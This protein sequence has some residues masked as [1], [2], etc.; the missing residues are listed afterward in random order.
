MK[1][2]VASLFLLA[3]YASAGIELGINLSDGSY[4]DVKS[5]ISPVISTSGGKENDLE[6]G[7]TVDLASDGLPKSIWGQKTASAE[8]WGVKTRVELTQGKYPY[9]GGTGAYVTVEA[10]DDDKETFLWSSGVISKGEGIRSLKVGAKKVFET[11]AGKIMIQPRRNFDEDSTEVVLGFEKD[12]TDAYL[13]ISGDAKDLLVK[14]KLDD[15]NSASLKIGCEGFISASITRESDLGS[16]KLTL[17]PDELDVE[18]SKDGWVAGV[19]CDKNLAVA[20]PKVRF[21][22][23]VSFQM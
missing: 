6:Y 23:G 12:D 20:E 22:K 17:T 1:F 9:T 15:S 11:D 18:I 5:A 4:G 19:S 2:T 14:Q 10:E 7:A 13:T 16:T 8:G 21:S 3:G